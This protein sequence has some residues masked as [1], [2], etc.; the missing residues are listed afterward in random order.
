MLH[1]GIDLDAVS[2]GD[3]TPERENIALDSKGRSPNENDAPGELLEG[4]KD[5]KQRTQ[6]NTKRSGG[7]QTRRDSSE[8]LGNDDATAPERDRNDDTEHNNKAPSPVGRRP[9]RQSQQRGTRDQLKNSSSPIKAPAL[10]AGK[11]PAAATVVPDARN[12]P[13]EPDATLANAATTRTRKSTV[14]SRRT[15]NVANG[16]S[17]S[18]EPLLTS[19]AMLPGKARKAGVSTSGDPIAVGSGSAVGAVQVSTGKVARVENMEKGAAAERG[20]GIIAAGTVIAGDGA[21]GDSVLAAEQLA[22][23]FGNVS[24]AERLATLFGN[25]PTMQ[26]LSIPGIDGLDLGPSSAV[27]AALPSQAVARLDSDTAIRVRPDVSE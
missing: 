19:R 20:G 24:A 18:D 10:A 13:N 2:V 27:I 14:A 7:R 6:K 26:G 9:Q 21:A 23:L 5:A 22:T 25:G 11:A 12:S 16:G 4:N 15:L 17:N 1:L 3:T 8:E